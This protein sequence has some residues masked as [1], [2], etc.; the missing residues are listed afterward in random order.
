MHSHERVRKWEKKW[1]TIE[2]TSMQIFKWVP[3]RL[4]EQLKQ[5]EL[6]QELETQTSDKF[7][8]INSEPHEISDSQTSFTLNDTVTEQTKADDLE[9][10]TINGN[11]DSSTQASD[12]GMLNGDSQKSSSN[13]ARSS[14]STTETGEKLTEPQFTPIVAQPISSGVVASEPGDK[15][16]A[17]GA[18]FEE[19]SK[20]ERSKADETTGA[21]ELAQVVDKKLEPVKRST[22]DDRSE[23]DT[24]KPS[25]D[26]PPTDRKSVV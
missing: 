18:V 4:E 7:Q 19:L 16:D 1:V 2:D 9:R 20:V 17:G 15:N 14:D 24:G 13:D 8:S 22:S 21:A 23:A 6:K 5:Q 26:E 11:G 12:K 25:L 10:L 3:V